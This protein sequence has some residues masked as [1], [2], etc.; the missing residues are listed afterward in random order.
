MK[1][2]TRTDLVNRKNV[3]GIVKHRVSKQFVPAGYNWGNE[4]QNLC[5]LL[6]LCNSES[7]KADGKISSISRFD[8]PSADSFL[9]RRVSAFVA[10]NKEFA[11]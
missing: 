11:R 5:S 4:N 7:S 1:T 9:R 2:P 3:F 6:A 8:F 10:G